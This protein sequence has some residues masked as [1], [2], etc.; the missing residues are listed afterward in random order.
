MSAFV[1]W[2]ATA[3]FFIFRVILGHKLAKSAIK[4]CTIDIVAQ[5]KLGSFGMFGVIVPDQG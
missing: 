3:K 5:S 4:L 1:N 2:G